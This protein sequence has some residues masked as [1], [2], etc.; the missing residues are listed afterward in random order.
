M[1]LTMKSATNT[2]SADLAGHAPVNQLIHSQNLANADT[3]MVVTPNVDTIYTQAWLDL[4]TEPMAVPSYLLSTVGNSIAGTDVTVK[5]YNTTA[6]CMQALKN[7]DAEGAVMNTYSANYYM[8]SGRTDSLNITVME[9]LLGGRL[10]AGLPEKAADRFRA[11]GKDLTPAAWGLKW[12]WSHPEVTVVLSGMRRSFSKR[13]SF[14]SGRRPKRR[15][16]RLQRIPPVRWTA[17]L[18]LT[19]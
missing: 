18:W 4:S 8:N 11:E 19:N 10:A 1:D 6:E 17:S 15:K 12:V 7:G 13:L 9:P 16:F 5:T 2:E 3:K 14:R